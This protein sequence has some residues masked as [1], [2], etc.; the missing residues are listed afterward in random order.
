MS[1][2]TPDY[3]YIS[4]YLKSR[5][6]SQQAVIGDKDDPKGAVWAKDDGSS[7]N[8]WIPYKKTLGDYDQRLLEVLI[9]LALHEASNG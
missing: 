4:D 3:S 1:E 9:Y 5:G 7:E 6:W 8:V 2:R